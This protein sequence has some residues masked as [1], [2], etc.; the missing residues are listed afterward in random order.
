MTAVIILIPL[1][2][3][4]TPLKS[5]SEVEKYF[6]FIQILQEILRN[7]FSGMCGT[8]ILGRLYGKG[9]FAFYNKKEAPR[10]TY[11]CTRTL[12]DNHVVIHELFGAKWT[13]FNF[14]YFMCEWDLNPLYWMVVIQCG[15]LSDYLL[16]F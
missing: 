7:V 2:D 10:Q 16:P 12:S 9:C 11:K 4:V 6:P 13:W 1:S 15:Q 14:Y 3:C 5:S 8:L